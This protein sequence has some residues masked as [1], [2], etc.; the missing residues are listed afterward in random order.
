[1]S[2]GQR[3][4]VI[5][6]QAYDIGGLGFS[7]GQPLGWLLSPWRGAARG[8]ECP[9]GSRRPSCAQPPCSTTCIAPD[10]AAP[11]CFPPSMSAVRGAT[12]FGQGLLQNAYINVQSASQRSQFPGRLDDLPPIAGFQVGGPWRSS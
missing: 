4:E 1:M 2:W 9:L 12:L 5:G 10:A 8:W 6:Y 7:G 3:F 11:R